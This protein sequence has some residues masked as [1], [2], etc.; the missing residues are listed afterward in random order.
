MKKLFL[1]I[2]IIMLFG[3]GC[4]TDS[5]APPASPFATIVSVDQ[6][7][8]AIQASVVA[9][10]NARTQADSALTKR[11]DDV[12][13][14]SG[15]NT[16]E[17]TKAEIDAMFTKFKTDNI[18][19]MNTKITQWTTGNLPNPNQQPQQQ[20]PL[21]SGQIAT[22]WGNGTNVA[23]VIRLTNTSTSQWQYIKPA[24]VIQ[25]PSPYA[26]ISTAPLISMQAGNAT[27][28]A[29]NFGYLPALSATVQSSFDIVPSS[30]GENGLGEKYLAPG[31]W[32]DVNVNILITSSPIN[33]LWTV[34]VNNR[35]RF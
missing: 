24:F 29:L 12:A 9:E 8:A 3:L 14:K 5:S 1:I 28:S 16:N 17:Y 32:A 10:A 31:N 35:S 11:V 21:A 27:W 4:A 13:G 19:P 15:A 23:F 6:K 2:P 26:A 30:G 33:A 25:T 18:D 34:Y 22:V 20:N 7:D